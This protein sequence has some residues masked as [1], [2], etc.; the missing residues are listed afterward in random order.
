MV[1][2]L[3]E[4]SGGYA[5]FKLLKDGKLKEL[6]ELHSN[7]TS[8]DKAE[9]VVKLKAFKKF[10]D[11]EEATECVEKLLEGE[12]SKTLRKFLDKNIVQKSIEEELFVADKKLG[13]AIQTELGIQCKAG[14]KANELLR[15]IRFQMQ[16][17]LASDLARPRCI[18]RQLRL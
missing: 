11:T 1:L 15:C 6:D 10:K 7:F 14:D 9:K 2:V 12:M 4:T 8:G 17:L 16:S 5:L 13:K 18:G 3:F